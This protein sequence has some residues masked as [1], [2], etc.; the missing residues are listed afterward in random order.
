MSVVKELICMLHEKG[1]SCEELVKASHAITMIEE[2]DEVYEVVEMVD[3]AWSVCDNDF[4]EMCLCI[5][6]WKD[7]F[8]EFID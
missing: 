4:E 8:E 6:N 5:E 1:F 2:R 3:I 7:Q